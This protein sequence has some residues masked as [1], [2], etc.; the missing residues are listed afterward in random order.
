MVC[1]ASTTADVKPTVSYT[2]L[3]DAARK[4]GRLTRYESCPTNTGVIKLGGYVLRYRV[5]KS[6]RAYD[7]VPITCS[8]LQPAGARRAAIEAVAFENPA[9][10]GNRALYDLAIPG[11]MA[12][13]LEYLGSVCADFEDDKYV[14]LTA[15]PKTPISPFPPY[16]RDP[17]G[18]SS[19]I[20]QAQVVWFKFRLT[21]TGDTILDPEGFGAAFFEPR[22]A[23]IASDG[24][25][26]WTAGTVNLF[27]RFT[28]YLYP[29]DSADMWVNFYIPNLGS[30]W[31]RGLTQGRYRIDFRMVYRYHRDYNWGVNIWTGAEF[32]RLAVPITVIPA[33]ASATDVPGQPSPETSFT[34]TD[35][36]DKTP[37]DFHA[38]EEFM[39]SFRIYPGVR[40]A[41]RRSGTVYLQVAPWTTRVTLKL[42]LTDPKQIVVARVPI[43]VTGETLRIRHNPRNVMVVREGDREVPAIVAQ[44]MPGMRTGFQLGPYPEFH[45]LERLRQLKALG[46][47]VI[48]NTAGGWWIP[49]ITG[50]QGVELHSACYKY[51]YDVL[52]RRV[53]LKCLGWSV[54]PPS[55]FSWYQHVGPLLG[56]NITYSTGGF[57]YGQTPTSVDMGDPVVPEVIAAWAIYNYS[58]WGDY[59]FVAK[60]GRIPIDIED[61]WGWMRDDIN[62]RYELGPLGLQR[63]RGW[64]RAKYGSIDGVN[65]AWSSTYASFDQID[66]QAGH[67]IEGDG[68][69]HGPVYNNPQNVFHDWSPA[70]E[71]WDVFRTE[72]RMDI[73]RRA[74]EIIRQTIPG[75]ELALRTEGANLTIKGDPRSENMHWRHVYYS[76]R[77][78]AMVQDAVDKANVLHFYS[79]YTTLPYSEE[80]WRQAM[81]QMVA[82]GIIPIFLPQFDHMR[83]ILLNPHYGRDYRM[84]YNLDK[85][86]KGMMVHC[87]MAAYPWW[88]ATYEE[89][90]APGIIYSDY[91]CDGFATETQ[92]REL[93]LLREELDRMHRR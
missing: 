68:L 66:P 63:F 42:I 64:L 49:E 39:T 86:T 88:K 12:V 38:F 21:N 90:G 80:E 67:G 35:T 23:R 61:T 37:G 46:V 50:R 15:D 3:S 14:P 51:F 19:V 33:R 73:Y 82:S 40:R 72:L 13:K 55:G 31:C 75:G 26:E 70:V 24:S 84:H 45:M 53:G 43:R 91:G 4:A 41:V 56:R 81:R 5:P 87:L 48:A 44:E 22:I 57:G 7:V 60:D 76:Q 71:D 92:K 9:R 83:D 74:N 78:N 52:M 20:R 29:G 8:L 30:E 11:D 6:A 65:R 54:Y 28:N 2:A 36:A 25:H 79:D 34:V 59:W 62:L 58:R 69:P 10:A 18:L 16:K 93:K 89:G 27:E 17:M 32:A 77:R 85:P 1:A 47:N